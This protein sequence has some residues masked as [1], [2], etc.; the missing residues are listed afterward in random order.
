MLHT[1][2]VPGLVDEG[3][4]PVIAADRAVIPARRIV[5]PRVAAFGA[6]RRP[7]AG[8]DRDTGVSGEAHDLFGKLIGRHVEMDPALTVDLDKHD[9]IEL[10]GVVLENAAKWG[11]SSVTVR[12]RRDG[13]MVVI[14]AE[15][16]GRGLP[17]DQLAD[18]GERGHRLDE[19]NPGTGLGWRSPRRSSG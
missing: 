16:D 10:L 18:L 4:P 3:R 12:G 9:L 6:C 5:R 1:E 2:P 7:S 17:P 13:A 11:R 15:D 8:F 14:A 19:S